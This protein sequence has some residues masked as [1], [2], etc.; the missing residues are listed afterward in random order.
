[1]CS[2]LDVCELLSIPDVGDAIP[3][4]LSSSSTVPLTCSAFFHAPQPCPSEGFRVLS[5]CHGCVSFLPLQKRVS[6]F[7]ILPSRGRSSRLREANRHPTSIQPLA[8]NT[9]SI[10]R[11][12]VSLPIGLPTLIHGVELL[13]VPVM[14]AQGDTAFTPALGR[15]AEEVIPAPERQE[16]PFPQAAS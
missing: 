7:L 9:L 14:D 15:W 6:F 1:M 12:I 11:A 5:A 3:K 4:L 13:S 8:H 10:G 2:T 16:K